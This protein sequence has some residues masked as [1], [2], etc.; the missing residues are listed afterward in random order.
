[1]TIGYD[2]RFPPKKAPTEVRVLFKFKGTNLSALYDVL[3]SF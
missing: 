2:Y 1:M 3:I